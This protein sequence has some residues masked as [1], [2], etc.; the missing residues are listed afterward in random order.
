MR[1]YLF[2][3]FLGLAYA[4]FS[5][6]SLPMIAGSVMG[7]GGTQVVSAYKECCFKDTFMVSQSDA[8][9]A[10]TKLLKTLPM[11]IEEV[12]ATDLERSVKVRSLYNNSLVVIK[13]KYVAPSLVRVEVKGR[14]HNYLPAKEDAQF[15]FRKISLR[16]TALEKEKRSLAVVP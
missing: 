7:V 3:T 9:I 13:V 12:N 8:V 5:S 10:I 2:L 14:K 11:T 1:T 6:C 16:L 15:V 4:L